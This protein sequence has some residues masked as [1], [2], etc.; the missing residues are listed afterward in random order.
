MEK[1]IPFEKLSKRKQR[2]LN[3]RK[4]GSWHGLNPVTR[5]PPNPKA[6][7]RKK[8]LRWPDEPLERFCMAQKAPTSGQAPAGNRLQ[9]LK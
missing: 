5:K 2:E 9:P 8:A 3:Q 1:Y 7:T 4:R 6:Y